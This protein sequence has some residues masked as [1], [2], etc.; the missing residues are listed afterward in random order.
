MPDPSGPLFPNLIHN[1]LSAIVRRLGLLGA[2][3]ES[4]ALSKT[5][6]DATVLISFRSVRKYMA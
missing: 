3:E 2:S 1:H 6:G 5:A 4:S